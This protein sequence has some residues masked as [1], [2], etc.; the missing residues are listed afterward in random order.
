MLRVIEEI[1]LTIKL[2]KY[3]RDQQVV[4][5]DEWGMNVSEDDATFT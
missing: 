2:M 5:L 4:D 3:R 1:K